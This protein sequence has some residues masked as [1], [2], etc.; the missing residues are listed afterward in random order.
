[1]GTGGA[2][3]LEFRV[4]G[5]FEVVSDGR[6]VPIGSPK[7]R[8]LMAMLVL[9]L[10]RVVSLDSIVDELWGMRPLAS[11][12]ASVQSLVSRLRHSLSDACPEGGKCLVG[13]EPGYVLEANRLQVD[14]HRFETLAATGWESLDRGDASGAAET[15]QEALGVWRGPALA[16]LADRRFARLEA[17]RLEE[18]RLGAV[19]E[20]VEAEL[21]VGRPERALAR[22]ET[23]V[24]ENPLRERA[25]GQLMV[26]LYRLGRQAD[27]L[28]AYQ[29]VRRV[30]RDD[31]GLEPTPWLRGLEE[32][33]LHQRPEL[34][35]LP[36]RMPGRVAEVEGAP[37]RPAGDT[38]VFLFT[39]IE[40]ST[41]RWEGDHDAMSE[42]LARHDRLL[43]EA[44]EE[45]RGRVFSHT[46][47][48]LCAAFPTAQG[49]L[50]A[51][52]AG[53]RGLLG[54]DWASA[55]PLRV[56]M[57][58]HAGAAEWRDGNY[59][60]PTLNRTARLLSLGH[61]GQVLC[62]QVAADLVRDQLP[63]D[64]S[65]VPLGEQ[66]LA[67]LTRPERVFQVRH[68]GL[69]SAFPPLRAPRSRRHN[70]PGT[71]TSFVGRTRELEEVRGLLRSA[72]LVTLT[73]VGGV[74]KTRLALE[75]VAGLLDDF[76]DGVWLVELG[77]V[78][79]PGLVAPTVMAALGLSSGA[80]ATAGS[81]TDRLCEYLE[82]RRVLL[83]FDN[84]E[85]LVDGTAELVHELLSRC[86]RVSIAA[87][88]RELFGLPGEV[89]WRVPPLSVPTGVVAG[90]SDLAGSDAVTLFYE[91]ARSAQAGFDLSA[92]NAAPVGQICRRLDGI[93]LALELAAARIRV[94]G[95][96]QIAER[97]DDRFRLL[98]GGARSSVPRHQTLRA[99]VDWSHDLLPVPERIA[100]RRL[101]VFPG[102]FDLEAAEAVVG[103]EGP[104]A[105]GGFE[106]LDLVSRLVDK[107]L[108]GVE[109]GSIEVRYRLLETVREYAGE[110]LVEAGE[111]QSSQRRHRDFFLALA[112]RY[113]F[114]EFLN[115]TAGALQAADANHD[116]FRSALEWSLDRGEHDLAL[117]LADFLW[118]YWLFTRPEEGADW[119]SKTLAA[120]SNEVTAVRAD[121]LI[122]QALILQLLGGTDLG[123]IERLLEDAR[124][125]ADRTHS[126]SRVHLVEYFLGDLA[127][128]RGDPK[129]AGGLLNSAVQGF[130]TAHLTIGS[131]WCHHSLGWLALAAG[132]LADAEAHFNQTAE[133]V[134]EAEWDKGR[135]PSD[136]DAHPESDVAV[137]CREDERQATG[138]EARI[139]IHALAGLAVV[140][141]VA[142]DPAR[143]RSLA[144]DAVTSA[145]LLPF[146]PA[147]VMALV[148]AAEVAALNGDPMRDA[149]GELLSV[150]CDLGPSSW[151]ADA[152]EMAALLHEEDGRK[153]VAARL[154][155]ASR[156]LRKASGG[157]IE[158]NATLADRL[159]ACRDR[160][161][162]DL[163]PEALT[164]HEAAGATMSVRDILA[165]A[166][167]RLHVP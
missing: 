127:L 32:Q 116:S 64:V 144:K 8:A 33:I 20:L 17:A 46:G 120:S 10:N 72:R 80:A 118:P 24:A 25:W 29:E 23:H 66:Q 95:A 97:L 136:A 135:R 149:L 41:R 5:T 58:I 113:P 87:T 2:D 142:G 86:P 134:R 91:R 50:A 130:E 126:V 133:L 146:R 119:V 111:T 55:A 158:G 93:P 61:G 45:G 145:R 152:I 151:A 103:D 22:L 9:H 106:V 42:D 6:V 48:G 14:S 159:R 19:E 154:L 104:A 148:R 138:G 1:M 84:C 155:G 13:R 21:A 69:P 57:A 81:V 131:A 3:A 156:E 162:Q 44:V 92:A 39:D 49:A 164:Q 94:L 125:M 68:H 129:A 77:P 161:Q 150:L 124:V 37:S 132:D 30:L 160:L 122:G 123:Q 102:S 71:L 140:A 76:P 26:T 65:L 43:R 165:L 157:P 163:G 85:H 15:L 78:S 62:S 16:D 73:G 100:L 110:K 112:E 7:Q 115:H 34:D 143:A 47:D 90:V 31:L 63:P 137:H 83:L 51:A 36:Q 52:V 67:D 105:G 59:V 101:A 114:N 54:E 74:G 53:Q 4:L 89:A 11:P 88:S 60:G 28:R 167:E 79:E 35:G 107:S 96:H 27:A 166:L 121:A 56:R 70:L 108:V 99:T 75:A 12:S 117:R 128:I 147:L 38:V 18:A 141:A 153:V 139:R 40:A 109:G 82:E 98:K